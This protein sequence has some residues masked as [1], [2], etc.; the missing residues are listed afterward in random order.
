[1]KERDRTVFILDKDEFVR[2]SLNKILNKYGFR[3]EEIENFSQLENRKKEIGRG[4]VLADVETDVLE[5]SIPL[6]RKWKERFVFMSPLI[7]EDLNLRLKKM[8]VRRIIKKP[9]EPRLLRRVIRE[10]CPSEEERLSSPDQGRDKGSRSI[11]KG[12]EQT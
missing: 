1:M 7:T 3:V 9:V 12:G 6:V 11:Q 5:K 2:L 8:G 10:I 4:I